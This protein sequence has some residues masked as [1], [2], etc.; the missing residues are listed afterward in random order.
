MASSKATD[1]TQAKKK[2]NEKDKPVIN[3]VKK[4]EAEELVDCPSIT[5]HAN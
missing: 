2:D 3:G 5:R 1:Q 4:D